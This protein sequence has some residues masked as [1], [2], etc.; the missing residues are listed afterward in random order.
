MKS[1]M[2]K[3]SLYLYLIQNFALQHGEKK[4]NKSNHWATEHGSWV[5][6]TLVINTGWEMR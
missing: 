3:D 4:C 1:L 6:T 5:R 2:S